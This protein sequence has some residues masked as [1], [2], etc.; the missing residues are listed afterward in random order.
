MSEFLLDP[1]AELA[2]TERQ[3]VPRLQSLEG[4]T[5]GLLDIS[6]P[7]GKEF[8]DEIETLLL[9]KG[10]RVNR[11]MKP[12]FARIA[13]RQLSQKISSECDAVIEGLAD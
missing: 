9:G 2:P 3:L 1:T 5:I 7:R 13:P 12:T 6:K 8:L 10:A 4:A 11:Y